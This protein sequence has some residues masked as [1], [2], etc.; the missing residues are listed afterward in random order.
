MIIN[1]GLIKDK[2]NIDTSYDFNKFIKNNTDIIEFKDCHIIGTLR[3][4]TNEEFHASLA[5]DCNM[6]LASSR[7]LKPVDYN[8]KFNLELVF[9]NKEDADYILTK[10]IDLAE[11]IYGHI[12]S[13]KPPTVYLEDEVEETI[14]EKKKINPAFEELTDWKK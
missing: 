7:S 6:I 11:I 10:S 1:P 3:Y 4:E 14:E 2:L 12:L 13:E 8:L 9:G 5:V